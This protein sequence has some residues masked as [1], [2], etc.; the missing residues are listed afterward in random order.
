[1][2]ERRGS[3]PTPTSSAAAAQGG[4]GGEG[5]APPAEEEPD[6]IEYRVGLTD[7][8]CRWEVS[9]LGGME[10]RQCRGNKLSRRGGGRVGRQQQPCR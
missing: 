8:K 6:L 4:G 5:A 10:L 2:L 7:V 1:M 9:G 3:L